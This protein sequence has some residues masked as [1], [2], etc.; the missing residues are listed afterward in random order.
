MLFAT[1][2]RSAAGAQPEIQVADETPGEFSA[3]VIVAMPLKRLAFLRRRRGR[4]G[5][6]LATG[7]LFTRK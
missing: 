3:A 4:S 7:G 2:L 1:L 6:L 5:L